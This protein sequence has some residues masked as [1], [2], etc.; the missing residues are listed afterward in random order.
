VLDG[1]NEPPSPPYNRRPRA[2]AEQDDRYDDPDD[3]LLQRIT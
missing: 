3:D 1:H 2:E